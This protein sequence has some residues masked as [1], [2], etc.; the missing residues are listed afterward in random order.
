MVIN[1]KRQDVGWEG[2]AVSMEMT[3]RKPEG[4]RSVIN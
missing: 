2:N 3:R 1:L 4:A